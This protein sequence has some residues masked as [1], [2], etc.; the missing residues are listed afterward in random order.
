MNLNCK[1]EEKISKK[2]G[3]KYICL[4]IEFPNGYKKIVFPE[5]N[6]EHFLFSALLNK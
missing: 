3:N 5:S 4:V 6:A 1:I 2:T